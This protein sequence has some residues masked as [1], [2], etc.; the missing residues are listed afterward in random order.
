MAPI[1]SSGEKFVLLGDVAKLLHNNYVQSF[2][3]S[4]EKSNRVPHLWFPV[5][6]LC[7]LVKGY[8]CSIPEALR[9]VAVV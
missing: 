1:L 4:V 2:A 6:G 5:V 9:V 3:E 7:Q 8:C